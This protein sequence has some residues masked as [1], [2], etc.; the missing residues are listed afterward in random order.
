MSDDKIEAAKSDILQ[1]LSG[2]GEA[3][4]SKSGLKVASKVRGQAFR[5]LVQARRIANM[6]SPRQTRFVLIEHYRP[7]EVACERILNKARPDVLHLFSRTRLEKGI[8]GAPGRKVVEAIDWLVGEGALL[9]IKHGRVS[10]YLHTS[11]VQ[12]LLPRAVGEDSSTPQADIEAEVLAA[13]ETVKLRGGFSDVKIY[14]LQRAARVPMD[15]LKTF[16]LGMSREG[17][18]VLSLGDWSLSSPEVRSGAVEIHGRP[19]LLVRFKK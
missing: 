12:A 18:A 2:A 13:Y 16:L 3:G 7:L 8:T 1:K 19:H 4:L 15:Q 5:E 17:R 14:D 11:S 6:G 10:Y 9:K